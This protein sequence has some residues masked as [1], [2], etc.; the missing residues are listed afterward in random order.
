MNGAAGALGP[1]PHCGQEH[2]EEVL[3]CPVKKEQLPLVGRLLAHKFRFERLLGEGGMGWVWAAENV[4]VK[5][6]V[7]IKLMRPEFASNPAI[8][9][10]FRNEATAAGQI[11]NPHICDILDFGQSDLGPFIVME[12]M[13]GRALNDLIEASGRLDPGLA[14]IIVRQA[15]E[16]LEAAHRAGIIHRDLKPENIFL[17]EPAPGRLLV[18]L[19]DFGIS[20]FS[21][22]DSAAGRTGVG[23]LMGTPEYMSPE[24]SQGAANVDERT[25]IWAMGLILYK[26]LTGVDAFA[27]PTVAATLVAVATREP[28]PLAGLAPYLPPGLIEIIA[29][30]TAKEPG[31]RFASAREL[32]DALAPYETLPPLPANFQPGPPGGDPAFTTAPTNPSIAPGPHQLASMAAAAGI[33]S[34]APGGGSLPGPVMSGGTFAANLDAAPARPGTWSSELAPPSAGHRSLAPEDS[35]SM[36]VAEIHDAPPGRS[37]ASG[38][39]KK[40]IIIVVLL[41]VVGGI[42]AGIALSL[43]GGKGEETPPVEDAVVAGDPGASAGASA[44]AGESAGAGASAAE[45]DTKDEDDDEEEDGKTASTKPKVNPD[46]DLVIYAGGFYTTKEAAANSDFDGAKAHCAGLKSKHYARLKG[47]KLASAKEVGK[48]AGKVDKYL[49]WTRDKSDEEGKAVAFVMVT[50][51]TTNR[52][53]DDKR[54]RPFCVA[55][56]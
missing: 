19:M 31:H 30:C 13:R 34:H 39:G 53:P 11:G 6:T 32:S 56:N 15:L 9:G 33:P 48:F 24:Q 1:C 43:G 14:V 5:K 29:R 54:A 16:G 8:L 27:G 2:P 42:G 52:P 36:G 44:G 46:K 3:V 4:L 45:S 55:K 22:A 10:R 50:K 41:L 49:Y 18:K 26:A 38:G 20:K 40:W 25:D 51:K 7:A 35:W 23:V 28:P 12:M 17:S 37:E 47:W 21:Q